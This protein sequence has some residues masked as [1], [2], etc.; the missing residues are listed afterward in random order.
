MLLNRY[1]VLMTL[2]KLK[3]YISIVFMLLFIFACKHTPVEN[4]AVNKGAIKGYVRDK[5]SMTYISLAY[6]AI[7]QSTYRTSDA[8]T[9][10]IPGLAKGTY[11]LQAFKPGYDTSYVTVTVLAGDTTRANFFLNENFVET[12][13]GTISGFVRDISTTALI[14]SAI[15]T[16]DTTSYLTDVTGNFN[17]T[18]LTPGYYDLFATK[19][20][21]DTMT[22]RINAVANE[23]A[24]A[25]FYLNF[26]GELPPPPE[27]TVTAVWKFTNTGINHIISIPSAVNPTIKGVAIEVGD[28]VGV[29]YDSSGV[30]ACAGYSVWNGG[31]IPV[32]AWGNDI[33]SSVK[34]GFST[35]ETFSWKIK[36]VSEGKSYNAVATYASGNGYFEN[37]GL[38]ILAT[39]KVE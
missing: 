8:G 25:N 33:T 36:D 27:D 31:N 2:S 21:Y 22:L 39:L 37:N 26:T 15:I 38:T 11:T 3:P 10:S 14:D 24:T 17:I 7:E 9:Y 16:F 32:T 29:F 6:V 23:I 28:L 34:D 5:N 18:G 4:E 20:G 1:Y 35:N 13:F 30:D 12:N 19:E